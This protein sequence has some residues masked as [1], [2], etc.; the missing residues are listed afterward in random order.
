MLNSKSREQ[1]F[2]VINIYAPNHYREQFIRTSTERLVTKTDTSKIIISG[3]W[4]TTLN[5]IDKLGG[6]PWK[7]T[8]FRNSIIDLMK[9]LDLLYIYRERLANTRTFTY[10]TKN[11]KLKFKIDFFPISRKV[12]VNLKR[13]KVHTSIVPDH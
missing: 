9:E 7:E 6:L 5:K 12:S 11:P 2:F 4:N 1:S 10:E 13:A 8:T 3:D